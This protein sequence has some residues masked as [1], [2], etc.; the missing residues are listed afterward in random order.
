MQ[1]T[2]YLA[3]ARRN[4]THR[5]GANFL[6]ILGL[7]IGLAGCVRTTRKSGSPKSFPAMDRR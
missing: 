4:L 7:S 2:H 3:A 1:L 6:N 5:K